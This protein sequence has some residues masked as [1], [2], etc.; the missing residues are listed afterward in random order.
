M[1]RGAGD[2]CRD[3]LSTLAPWF[4]IPEANTEYVEAAE[5]G[6]SIVASV[7]GTDVGITVIK[8][9][10]PEAAEVHLMAVRSDHRRQG[11]GRQMLRHAESALGADGVRFLQVKTL[12]PRR[13][14]AGYDETRA[15]YGAYG[16]VSLEEFPEL[17]DLSNP[18]L[19]MIKTVDAT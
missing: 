8:R 14:D 2:I 18:A 9:H 11:A 7:D 15:F 5:A 6:P 16:F 12:S 4:G 19:Q 17:W 1:E 3:I 10:F 13:I